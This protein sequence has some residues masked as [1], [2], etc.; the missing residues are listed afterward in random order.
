MKFDWKTKSNFWFLQAM[1]IIFKPIFEVVLDK[2][3]TKILRGFK[4]WI[5][6]QLKHKTTAQNQATKSRIRNLNSP[7]IKKCFQRKIYFKRFPT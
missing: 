3:S 7:A 2:I 1:T 4:L 5:I 6:S